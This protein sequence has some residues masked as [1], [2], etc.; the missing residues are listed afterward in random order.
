MPLMNG[1]DASKQ[2]RRELPQSRILVL[3]QHDSSHLLTAAIEAGA[4]GYV[5]KSQVAHHLLVA[6]EAVAAGQSFP[7]TT[8]LEAVSPKS[9]TE[10]ASKKRPV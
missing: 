6:L 2:I 7:W 10:G 9:G 1:L 3:S 8:E 4:S 5:T